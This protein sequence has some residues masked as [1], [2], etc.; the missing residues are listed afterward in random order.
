MRLLKVLPEKFQTSERIKQQSYRVRKDQLMIRLQSHL[1][2]KNLFS[3]CQCV[4]HCYCQCWNLENYSWNKRYIIYS[5][6]NFLPRDVKI[7]K[8]GFCCCCC[9]CCCCRLVLLLLLLPL[10][11]LL[12]LLLLAEVVLL[13][14]VGCWT[15]LDV[16]IGDESRL[17]AL[18]LLFDCWRC[19]KCM[20]MLF[21]GDEAIVDMFI[22]NWSP[23]GSTLVAEPKREALLVP[24]DGG[25]WVW[26]WPEFTRGDEPIIWEP[27][28]WLT[29]APVATPL[30]DRFCIPLRVAEQELEIASGN[31]IGLITVDVGF[32]VCR[33]SGKE[34][35]SLTWKNTKHP[36][37]GFY[38]AEIV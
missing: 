6:F 29:D 19:A 5:Q 3:C 8:S 10:L 33:T 37:F 21:L 15:M 28:C 38:S 9:C 18:L 32:R 35:G 2:A 14:L 1:A 23:P 13:L 17:E 25:C 24:T 22:C 36:F 31:Y 20:G 27:G 12:L 34:K 7:G 30:F 26:A 11:L 4:L 16:V